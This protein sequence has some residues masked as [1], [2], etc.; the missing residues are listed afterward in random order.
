MKQLGFNLRETEYPPQVASC[1]FRFSLIDQTCFFL[2]FFKKMGESFKN[3]LEVAIHSKLDS[4]STD[5]HFAAN[6]RLDIN[7]FPNNC[8][9]MPVP[10]SLE[11][12]ESIDI[13]KG[14]FQQNFLYL[15]EAEKANL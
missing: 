13:F 3:G 4:L 10:V 15:I 14:K 7:E 5:C 6:L 2:S 11:V 1:Q 8:E 12:S 9:D